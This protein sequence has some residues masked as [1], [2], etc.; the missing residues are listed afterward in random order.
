MS[1]DIHRTHGLATLAI[2]QATEAAQERLTPEQIAEVK[3]R[4]DDGSGRLALFV[5]NDGQNIHIELSLI[6]SE[7]KS[8]FT[9]TLLTLDGP[10]IA[11]AA[12]PGSVRVVDRG[13]MN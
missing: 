13:A 11:A 3:S 2:L 10:V 12:T 1:N 5:T 8:V 4:V 7:H 6:P 9:K